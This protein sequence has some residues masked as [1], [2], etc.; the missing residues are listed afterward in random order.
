MPIT[1][2]NSTAEKSQADQNFN[3]RRLALRSRKACIKCGEPIPKGTLIERIKHPERNSNVWIHA[4][5][6]TESVIEVVP[7]EEKQVDN[8]Q[9]LEL[10]EQVESLRDQLDKL[11]AAAPKQIEIKVADRKPVKVEGLAHPV[12][13]EVIEMMEAREPLFIVG[14][15]GSGKTHLAEQAAEVLE[16]ERF[17]SISCTAGM[18]ESQIVGRAIPTGKAGQ[19]TYCDTPFLDCYE[20]GGLFLFDEMDAADPN[21]LLLIN[22]AMSNGS[23][24]IPGRWKN[25]IAVRHENFMVIAAANTFGRGADRLYN[26]RNA[27]DFAT[28]KRFTV[29]KLEVGYDRTLERQLWDGHAASGNLDI[30]EKMWQFRDAIEANG[31]EQAITT[32]DLIAFAKATTRGHELGYIE[33]KVFFGWRDDEI[34]KVRNYS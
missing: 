13:P 18:S 8:E 7:A 9:L 6:S 25:P 31:L 29:G 27:L 26:G 33:G 32:R 15:T 2:N 22:S 30:L 12:L 1:I 16:C 17:G 24:R 11:E 10:Q 21:V 5:C 3:P 20:K 28:M 14:P 4:H 23:M 34:A 19:F